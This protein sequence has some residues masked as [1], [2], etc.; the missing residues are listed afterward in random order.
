MKSVG[1]IGETVIRR[2]GTVRGVGWSGG[3]RGGVGTKEVEGPTARPSPSSSSSQHELAVGTETEAYWKIQPLSGKQLKFGSSS[4]HL[5][6]K[7]RMNR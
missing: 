3:G 7:G 1:G 2:R 5:F 6:V 4:L